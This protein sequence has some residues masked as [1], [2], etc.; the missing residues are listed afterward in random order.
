MISRSATVAIATLATALTIV[1]T[2]AWAE[3]TETPKA[4]AGPKKVVNGPDIAAGAQNAP[5][6]A[7]I[8]DLINTIGFYAIIACLV[9]LLLSGLILAVGPRLG[10]T[11]GRGK[12]VF[13]E[14]SSRLMG[15]SGCRAWCR[16]VA[17]ML[18]VPVIRSRLIA[19]LRRVAIMRGPLPVRTCER[20]SS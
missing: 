16:S 11:Q 2:I 8:T 1:P 19:R 15:L 14:V 12:V 6:S 18:A 7:A 5:G 10:F 9:G 17:A 20:S 4:P 3:P 13:H